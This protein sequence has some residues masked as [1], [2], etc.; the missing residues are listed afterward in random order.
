VL[1]GIGE[2][3]VVSLEAVLLE[4]LLI[5]EQRLEKFHNG[6][7]PHKQLFCSSAEIEAFNLPDTLDI[8]ERVLEAEQ[9]VVSL[10]RHCVESVVT[11]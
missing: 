4:E 10:G 6:A 11:L 7:Q 3:G 8:Q 9:F 2:D 5:T 1:L